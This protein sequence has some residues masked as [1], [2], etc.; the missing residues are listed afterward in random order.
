VT[1]ES[2]KNDQGGDFDFGKNFDKFATGQA[3]GGDNPDDFDFGG[4]VI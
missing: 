4:D 3:L 1:K 2:T